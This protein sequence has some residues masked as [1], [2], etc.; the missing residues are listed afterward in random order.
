MT[1]VAVFGASGKLGRHIL[2][3][4][5]E[6]DMTCRALIHHTPLAD[7]DITTIKGSIAEAEAVNE[8]VNGADIVVQMATTKEDPETFFEVSIKGTFNIL[9]AC[10]QQKI[11][12]FILLGGDAAF[13]IWFYPQPKP[14]DEGHRLEAYPGHYAFSKVME[15]S[16][17]EQYRIQYGLPV[18]VLRSSWVHENDDLLN[19]FSLLKNVDPSEKGHG[20]GAVDEATLDLV[21]GGEERVPILLD[22]DGNPFRRHIVHIDDVLQGFGKMLN[23]PKAFGTSFNIAGPAA[24]G[25]REAADHLSQ[26]TGVPTHEISCP[27]YHSFEIAIGKAQRELGYAPENDIFRMI[28]R[29]LEFRKQQ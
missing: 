23:E 29:A 8:V 3:L 7:P 2:P 14:I 20:F 15:E 22:R 17:A 5:K 27:D 10:R 28:D 4:L 26:R 25:Y 6:R 21:R 18:T 24:F 19:H 12:Q 13:G 9:E 1:T 11:R 16:M